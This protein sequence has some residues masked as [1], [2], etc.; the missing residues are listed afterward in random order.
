MAVPQRPGEQLGLRAIDVLFDRS[1]VSVNGSWT[2]PRALDSDP[3][4]GPVKNGVLHD[5]PLPRSVLDQLLPRCAVLLGLPDTAS[6]AQVAAT[7]T[8]PLRMAEIVWG[9]GQET[10]RQ[11]IPLTDTR[12]FDQH[13]FTW[14][15]STPQWKW[16]RVALWDVAGNGA[17]TT[18]V[19]KN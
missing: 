13:E 18:P 7:W 6:T 1:V 11:T 16:A 10:H 17:F 14:K 8:F 3:F 15:V 2:Q 5:V 12:E 4:R 19:W 9:D